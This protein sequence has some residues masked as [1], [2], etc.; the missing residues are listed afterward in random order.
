MRSSRDCALNRSASPCRATFDRAYS[1]TMRRSRDR[2]NGFIFFLTFVVANGVVVNL[3]PKTFERVVKNNAYAIVAFCVPSARSCKAF[4][5]EFRDASKEMD[6]YT[7][8]IRFATMNTDIYSS[9]AEQ[10]RIVNH[11]TIW[12]FES[13]KF[14]D[15][16]T[17]GRIKD[18]IVEW[19]VKQTKENFVN[20]ETL[21]DLSTFK[22]VHDIGIFGYLPSQTL[23]NGTVVRNENLTQFSEVA[24]ALDVPFGR[25][26]G[27]DAIQSVFPVTHSQKRPPNSM[28]LLYPRFQ[29]S[30][31]VLLFSPDG[32]S[33]RVGIEQL[34]ATS[35]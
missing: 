3:T 9:F 8:K 35:R 26:V 31:P 13:G 17:G 14:K 30:Q 32:N 18:S 1:H 12:W 27:K 7:P 33:A 25:L 24:K 20:I 16:Y 10:K 19:L 2:W 4:M 5:P 15:V 28:I 6:S 21:D 29:T 23:E 34:L 22:I 11:P